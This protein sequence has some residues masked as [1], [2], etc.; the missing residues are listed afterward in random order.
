MAKGAADVIRWTALMLGA[1]NIGMDMA[2][3]IRYWPKAALLL[4]GHSIF[5]NVPLHVVMISFTV[6]CAVAYDMTDVFGRLGKHLTW[7]SPVLVVIFA[8]LDIAV[9]LIGRFIG[10]HGDVVQRGEAAFLE[11]RQAEKKERSG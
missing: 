1:V 2:V 3:L 11:G 4:R 5:R 7:R 8:G 10:R 6:A 9:F